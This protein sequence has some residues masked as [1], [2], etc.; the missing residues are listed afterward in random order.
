MKPPKDTM[1]EGTSTVKVVRGTPVVGG[2][3]VCVTQEWVDKTDQLLREAGNVIRDFI[4]CSSNCN[5]DA[6]KV[7]AK[8]KKE[9]NP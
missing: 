9:L 7:F 6:R 3:V 4:F 5:C 1:K 8:L 2:K